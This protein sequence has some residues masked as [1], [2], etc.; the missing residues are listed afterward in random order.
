MWKQVENYALNFHNK[1]RRCAIHIKLA[2]GNDAVM[3]HLTSE[4]LNALG[5]ILRSEAQVWYH[6]I[7]GDLTAHSAP[8]HE[9]DLD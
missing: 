5:N 7:R 6:T 4:E 8:Q 3:D 9:E 1:P 2:D